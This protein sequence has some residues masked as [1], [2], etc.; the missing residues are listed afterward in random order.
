MRITIAFRTVIIALC[1]VGCSSEGDLSEAKRLVPTKASEVTGSPDY[2]FER[3]TKSGIQCY[4]RHLSPEVV[5][6]IPAESPDREYLTTGKEPCFVVPIRNDKIV[7]LSKEES[8]EIAAFMIEKMIESD[9][10]YKRVLGGG[11]RKQ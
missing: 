7:K 5:A 10:E 1:L 3:T 2:K 11:G 6:S 4:I 8:A 9:P